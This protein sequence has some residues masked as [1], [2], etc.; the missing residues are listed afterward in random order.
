MT[1]KDLVDGFSSTPFIFWGS[2]MSRRYLNLPDWKSLL[3]YFCSQIRGD[4]FSYSAYE[5]KAKQQGCEYGILPKIAE[6]VQRDY[7]DAWFEGKVKRTSD[8]AA[9][10]HIKNGVSPFKVEIAE[11]IKH[12]TELQEKYK[13][14]IEKLCELSRNSISGVITTNYDDF[15]EN[16]F[17]GFTKYVGQNQLIFSSIQGV[18][19]IYKIHGSVELPNSIVINEDDYAL[20]E[21]KGAYL[22]SKLLTI[23]MEYPIVFMGYSISDSNVQHIIKSIVDCLDA[24]QITI[25]ENRF[26]FIEFVRGQ[27]VPEVSPYTI[28]IDGKPLQLKKVCMDDYMPFYN[29]LENKKTKLPVRILRRFKQELYNYT[30]TNKTTANLRVASI[31]DE[32]VADEELVLAIGRCSEL[33]LRGLSGIDANDWIRNI[34]LEDLEFTADELLEI[35]FPKLIKQNSGRLPV[36]KYLSMAERT[37]E[38]AEELAKRQTFDALIS[39]T[40]KKERRC[41]K[42]YGSIKEIWDREGHNLERATRL[43]A[44]LKEDHI[45]I[46]EL[47]SVLKAIFEDDVNILRNSQANVRTNIRR[48][49]AIYDC[50]KWK[51]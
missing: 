24:E 5:N 7:D 20:F 18:A 4:E 38:D 22:A 28:M 41:V 6:L 12:N 34:I 3:K 44:H 36:N 1:V 39:N 17:A 51:Q 42:E 10:Q 37:H 21:K 8:D 30:L 47:E 43:M 29:A 16:H 14:E 23:F 11:Y 50:L 33:G 2:G 26:V 48:L 31:E 35:A 49:V 9:L 46:E 27:V 13:E 45:D 15:L 19:E 25:L 32:R 40:I